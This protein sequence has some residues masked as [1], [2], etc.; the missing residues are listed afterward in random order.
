MPFGGKNSVA[1]WQRIVD[2][3]LAGVAFAQAYADDILVWSN[4]NETEHI[5]RLRV[6]MDRLHQAGVQISPKKCKLGMRRVEFLGHIISKDG[7]EPQWD[8]IEAIVNLPRPTT[9]SEVRSFIG[10]ATYYCKFLEHYSHVKK[11][12]T[13]LTKKDVSFTWGPDQELAFLAIK[14]ILVS[15]PVLRDPDWTRPFMLHTDWSKVGVGATLSQVGQDGQEYAIAYASRMNSRAEGAFSSYEGEVS[16]VVYAVQRFRYWLWGRPFR[17]YTDCKAMQW[18]TTTARLRSKIARWSLILAEY[19]MEIVHRAGKDNTVPDLLSRLPLGSQESAPPLSVFSYLASQPSTPWAQLARMRVPWAVPILAGWQHGLT[20]ASK[21]RVDVWQDKEALQF[22]RHELPRESVIGSRWDQLQR[23]CRRY[24]WHGSKLWY[25]SPEGHRLEVPPPAERPQL[26]RRVHASIGHLGRDRTYAMSAQRYYWPRMYH[27]VVEALRSC[28][29]CDRVR[30]SF[31]AKAVQLHP[32]PIMGLFYRFHLDAAVNLPE[33]SQ[34]MRHV[35]I[36][37][38]AFSK[39]VDLIPLITL[40][41]ATVTTTF[42]ERVLAR[43]GRPVEVVTDNG[44][45]YKAEFH[46]LLIHHGIEHRHTAP[47]HPQANGAA[48]RMVQVLKKCLRKYVLQKGVADWHTYIPTIEFGYRVTPQRMTGY[49][50]YFLLYGRTPVYPEQARALL[51]GALIDVDNEDTVMDLIVTRA[52]ALRAAMP[53]AFDNAIAAQQRDRIRYQRVR[54]RDLPP[55]THRFYVG[56]YVYVAQRPI[57]TLDVRTS[58]TILRVREVHDCGTLLLEGSDGST[59]IVRIEQ[60]AP[61]RIPN[62]VT[63]DLGVAAELA[64]QVC[65]SP[66]MA[67]PMLICDTCDSGWHI[68]CLAPPLTRVP[69]GDW[70]CPRCSNVGYSNMARL[71]GG[72]DTP[73]CHTACI[74][75]RRQLSGGDCSS[76]PPASPHGYGH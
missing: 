74:T 19:D 22:L 76:V 2:N 13:E 11:P 27:A 63:S 44:S 43:Y 75:T 65:N 8:K 46:Q 32:L 73:L 41:A 15:A 54:R 48:E 69:D 18:L 52:A 28:S 71:M 55:R 9:I 72:N 30:A 50:P 64:C 1:C 16:A 66:T 36:I 51:D 14:R 70:H 25:D 62:L 17:L 12:L 60:C 47:A 33:S 57:N 67:D 5:R 26:I 31:D 7:V 29:V 6:V 21:R 59:V 37:V 42:E 23:I 53:I 61:C 49:S 68:S 20:A 58:R 39:W 4:G 24:T 10:M 40:D 35:L 34:G 3:A 38:E 45:E 56:D